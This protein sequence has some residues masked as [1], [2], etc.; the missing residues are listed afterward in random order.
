MCGEGCCCLLV[1]VPSMYSNDNRSDASFGKEP[2]GEV[3]VYQ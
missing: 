1:P 3:D 2:A